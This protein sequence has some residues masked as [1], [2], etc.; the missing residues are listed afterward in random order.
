MQKFMD[1]VR[2][3]TGFTKRDA[4]AVAWYYE[5]GLYTDLGVKSIPFDFE[6]VSDRVVTE[7]NEGKYGEKRTKPIREI[8]PTEVEARA[9]KEETE[10]SVSQTEEIQKQIKQSGTNEH[11]IKRSE[12]NI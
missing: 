6:K 4:Q 5:Q 10:L 8:S 7:I 2:D 11:E 3:E 12:T 1:A 9:T